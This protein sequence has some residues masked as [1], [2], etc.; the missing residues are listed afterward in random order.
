MWPNIDEGITVGKT[1]GCMIQKYGLQ[2]IIIYIVAVL[3][4]QRLVKKITNWVACRICGIMQNQLYCG[5]VV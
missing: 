2:D 4:V 5:T 1:I 3:Y